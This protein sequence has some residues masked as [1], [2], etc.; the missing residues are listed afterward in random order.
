MSTQPRIA[1]VGGGIAGLSVAYELSRRGKND[2]ILFEPSS[3]LG[4][5]VETVRR[6]GFVI[7]CGPDSWVTEKP[8][9]RQLAV[10]LGLEDEIIQSNDEHRRTYLLEDDKLIAMPDGMRM[11]VP[12]DLEAIA[13]SPFFTEKARQAYQQEISRAE[14]LKAFAATRPAGE[15]ESIASF[16][17]RHFGPEVTEKIAAPLLAG[18]FGG[19]IRQLSA[20]AV[21]AP[22]VTMEREHGSLILALQ[23]RRERKQ[24]VFTTLKNGLESLIEAMS[25]T[26][27]SSAIRLSEPVH[28]ISPK[29]D[30]WEVATL[31]GTA[32][33]DQVVLATPVHVAREL[34]SPWN[35]ELGLLLNFEATSSVVAAFA[36]DQE[37]SAAFEVPEGFGF[38]VP[39]N[40]ED[41]PADSEPQLLACTFVDQKFPHRS[42]AGCTLLRVFY[43]GNS[44]PPLLSAPDEAIL[45]LAHSQLSRIFPGLQQP[46]FSLVRRL[47]RSLPQYQVGHVARV[48]RIEA[49][50][51][52]IHGL[53]IVGNAFHGV[54]LP[55]LIRQGRSVAVDISS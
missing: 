33:F 18:V 1:I 25:G 29:P 5:I 44:A 46:H 4:G 32:S 43:G 30:G 47:P 10:E 24:S 28:S 52:E 2:F 19:D 34:I 36:F 16:V 35:P 49:T 3:H 31:S 27:P 23:N 15:D 11:M 55:D 38:L 51:R 6:D 22:F 45:V 48:A 41:R 39:Q 13:N 14:E 7:E 42:P 8:W 50:V 12:T 53:H 26:I 20:A 17:Q 40:Y 37:Q 9:A 21:M 54:G